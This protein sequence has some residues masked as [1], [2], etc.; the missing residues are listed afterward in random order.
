M[1]KK[2]LIISSCLFLFSFAHAETCPT[3]H[4]LKSTIFQQQGWQALD[5]DNGEPLSD[6]DLKKFQRNVKTFSLATW[7]EDAPE[8]AGQCYYSGNDREPYMGVYIAKQTL[9]PDTRQ[10]NWHQEKD[11]MKCD[12]SIS[13]CR[14]L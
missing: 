13:A 7:L 1:Q 14:Y 2:I 4:N 11:V 8:G 10:G 5:T 12:I 6:E 3:V 9:P